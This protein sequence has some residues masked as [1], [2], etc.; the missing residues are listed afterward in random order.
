MWDSITATPEPIRNGSK[1][2]VLQDNSKTVWYGPGT[3]DAEKGLTVGLQKSLGR[4]I[5]VQIPAPGTPNPPHLVSGGN[6][7]KGEFTH[8][9]EARADPAG[10]VHAPAPERRK[11]RLDARSPA[12]SANA[13]TRFTTREAEGTWN[14]RVKES[15]ETG[16][17]G[18]SAESEAIKVDQT[19]PLTPT[20]HASR[21]PDYALKGGWYKDSVTV[22]FTS[23]GDPMLADHSAPSGVKPGR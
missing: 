18:Y 4:L 3:K 8:Q 19:A 22:S 10:A 2:E 12:T 13:N 16:E 15:N 5:T 6:P 23:N 11:R 14:Y 17:S 1:P 7:N 21:A 20:P 9:M